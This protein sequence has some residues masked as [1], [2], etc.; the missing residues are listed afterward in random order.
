[1]T[2]KARHILARILDLSNEIRTEAF[3][4]LSDADGRHLIDLLARVHN[5]LSERVPSLTLSEFA[6]PDEPSDQ[7]APGIAIVTA[8]L[9]QVGGRR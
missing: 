2:E 4:G 7:L 6:D 1:M 8:G 3:A 9:P 5:N